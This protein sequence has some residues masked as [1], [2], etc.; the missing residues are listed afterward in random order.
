MERLLRTH[1]FVAGSNSGT[2]L[3][4]EKGKIQRARDMGTTK[5]AGR[6]NIQVNTVLVEE[7]FA[8]CQ[9]L[10]DENSP[11]SLKKPVLFVLGDLSRLPTHRTGEQ[12][13]RAIGNQGNEKK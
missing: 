9:E 7:K 3:V 12:K 8:W 6:A 11:L 10:S 1:L 2:L 5:F 13:L 4:G